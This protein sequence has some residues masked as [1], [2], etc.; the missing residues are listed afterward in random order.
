M[1]DLATILK[2]FG[3]DPHV[4]QKQVADIGQLMVGTY[5]ATKRIE[6][7]LAALRAELRELKNGLHAHAENEHR[8]DNEHRAASSNLG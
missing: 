2:S 7:E 1:F 4:I 3:L 6:T 8:A 5:E